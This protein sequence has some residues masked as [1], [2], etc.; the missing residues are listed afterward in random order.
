MD[1]IED[2][3]AIFVCVEEERGF[4]ESCPIFGG[5]QIQVDGGDLFGYL[6]SEGCLAGLTGSDEGHSRHPLQSGFDG[7][8][9]MTRDHPCILNTLCLICKVRLP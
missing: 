7:G 4:R 3:Q 8:E 2:Y 5:L 1:F 6:V 9:C